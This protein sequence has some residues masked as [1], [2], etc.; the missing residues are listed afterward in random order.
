MTEYIIE[1]MLAYAAGI[2]FQ[3]FPIRTMRK[4]SVA[5]AVGDAVKADTLSLVAFEV[6]M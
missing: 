2:A 5:A 6:G 3:Y 1:L 4:V